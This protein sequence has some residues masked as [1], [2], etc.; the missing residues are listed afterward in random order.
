MKNVKVLPVVFI[1][2]LV[3]FP[4]MSVTMT[5]GREASRLAIVDSQRKFDGSI[6]TMTQRRAEDSE[7]TSLDAAYTIGTLCKIEKAVALTDGGMQVQIEGLAR[8]EGQELQLLS[9]VAQIKG[10]IL[11]DADANLSWDAT[12]PF[13]ELST[14]QP[15]NADKI[16][17]IERNDPAELKRVNEKIAQRQKILVEPSAKKRMQLLRDFEKVEN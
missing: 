4:G 7:I 16:A 8:F 5:V 10:E 17:W 15:F 12:K 11:P 1:R 2:E 3:V 14:Y 9:D 6:V 13:E